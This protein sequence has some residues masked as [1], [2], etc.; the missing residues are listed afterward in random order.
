MLV[1]PSR[2]SLS[3]VST[4]NSAFKNGLMNDH[5]SR[6]PLISSSVVWLSNQ[7]FAN[8]QRA[9]EKL[10][11]VVGLHHVVNVLNEFVGRD[12]V[13]VLNAPKFW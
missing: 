1:Y 5:F 9:S 13:L 11:P 3:P 7:V 6:S 8:P 2:I 12:R 10:L 4:A